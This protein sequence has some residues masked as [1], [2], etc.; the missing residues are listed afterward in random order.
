MIRSSL[1]RQ[2]YFLGLVAV[3]TLWLSLRVIWAINSVELGY[4]ADLGPQPQP[5]PSGNGTDSG[6]IPDGDGGG[7]PAMDRSELIYMVTLSCMIYACVW[8]VC[9]LRASQFYNLLRRA[10]GAAA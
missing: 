1:T 9:F 2:T 6:D 10:N 5:P 3:G 7:V 4:D 8:S